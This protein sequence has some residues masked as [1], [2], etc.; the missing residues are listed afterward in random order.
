[1]TG[2]TRLTISCRASVELFG[3]ARGRPLRVATP[4]RLWI[5]AATRRWV[6]CPRMARR[7]RRM[8]L[9]PSSRGKTKYINV[10]PSGK[11]CFLHQ[12]PS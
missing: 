8:H 1:M 9:S 2:V 6:Q 12:R 11:R 10:T 7:N 5:S 4:V 3:M